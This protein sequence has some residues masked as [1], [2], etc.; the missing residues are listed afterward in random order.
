MDKVNARIS[1]DR[2][3]CVSNDVEM[4]LPED[5]E[6]PRNVNLLLVTKWGKVIIGHWRDHDCAEWFPLPARSTKN[7]Q[8]ENV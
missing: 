7:K 5:F 1:S 6:P 2:E 4:L 3:R 8:K